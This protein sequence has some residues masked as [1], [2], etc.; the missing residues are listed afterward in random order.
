MLV[1]NFSHAFIASDNPGHIVPPSTVANS[2][3]NVG[4]KLN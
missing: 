2:W 3:E 1:A 4:S